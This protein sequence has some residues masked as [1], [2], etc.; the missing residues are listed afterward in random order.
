[1][2]TARVG[3]CTT[4]DEVTYSK[5]TYR[6][7]TKLQIHNAMAMHTLSASGQPWWPRRVHGIILF[8]RQQLK[9]Y[10]TH[11]LVD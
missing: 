4:R 8:I 5:G 7:K 1:M 11:K 10:Y 6:K 9:A 3:A 2:S